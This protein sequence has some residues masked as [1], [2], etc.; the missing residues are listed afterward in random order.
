MSI[1]YIDLSWSRARQTTRASEGMQ[2]LTDALRAVYG[3]EIHWEMCNLV[4][5]HHRTLDVSLNSVV[6]QKVNLKN[7]TFTLNLGESRCTIQ[8]AAPLFLY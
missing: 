4:L 7:F 5:T 8:V 6:S 1:Q 3:N 2:I